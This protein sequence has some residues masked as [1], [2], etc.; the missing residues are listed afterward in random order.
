LVCR[1]AERVH[2]ATT[3]REVSSFHFWVT[4]AGGTRLDVYGYVDAYLVKKDRWMVIVEI[5]RGSATK[6]DWDA[7]K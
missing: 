6:A 7:L 3:A 2:N 1:S 5:H 4:P